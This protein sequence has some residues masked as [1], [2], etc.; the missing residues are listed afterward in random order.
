MVY[1][2]ILYYIMVYYIILYYII[3]YYKVGYLLVHHVARSATGERYQHSTSHQHSTSPNNPRLESRMWESGSWLAGRV[4]IAQLLESQI[5]NQPS[6]LA[7]VF[8][9]WTCSKALTPD[10]GR[11][12]RPSR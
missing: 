12:F 7:G 4:G 8:L 2:I 9:V 10:F 1:F 5:C 11:G 6:M 3:L